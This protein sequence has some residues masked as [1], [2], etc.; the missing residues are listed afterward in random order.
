MSNFPL[1]LWWIVDSGWVLFSINCYIG[2]GSTSSASLCLCSARYS[3]HQ[4]ARKL[5][6]EVKY[7]WNLISSFLYSDGMSHELLFQ[8]F[9]W[10]WFLTSKKSC[11]SNTVRNKMRLKNEFVYNVMKLHPAKTDDDGIFWTKRDTNWES[12]KR[13][14]LRIYFVSV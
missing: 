5:K 12:K 9:T 4:L 3:L 13:C 2:G 11:H 8:I 7:F 14:H 10:L 6:I 1:T